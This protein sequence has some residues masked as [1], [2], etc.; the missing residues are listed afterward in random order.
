M[1]VLLVEDEPRVS[2]FIAA[3]LRETGHVVDLAADGD[4][5]LSMA[6]AGDYDAVILDVRLPGDL[7]G[8]QVAKEL[9]ASRVATP[10]I[11]LT[12]LDS[13]QDVIRGLDAGA[14][15]YVTKPFDLTELEA[16]LRSLARRH[17]DVDGHVLRFASIDL[18][19]IDRVVRRS[20]IP[21]NLTPTEFRLLAT[22]MRSP[23]R[24]V[25]RA[26][27]RRS[28][29]GMGFDPGT[30]LVDVHIANLRRKLEAGGQSRLISTERGIGF[31]LSD[32][33]SE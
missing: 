14:D 31:R 1:K 9:R 15:D 11:M 24:A 30:R 29:F 12:A 25:T 33:E 2:G 32:P 8:F 6:L 7:D 16:R 13:T 19:P 26:N 20:G 21:I 10:I 18:D 17:D 23:D 27:L 4:V 5:G 3:G 28:V 22:L